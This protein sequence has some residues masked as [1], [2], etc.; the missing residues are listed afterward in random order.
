MII[1]KGVK[2]FIIIGEMDEVAFL[3]L[4]EVLLVL[5]LKMPT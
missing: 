4:I 1:A 3:K 5:W 2:N